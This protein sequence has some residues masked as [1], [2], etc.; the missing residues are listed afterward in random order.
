MYEDIK[1]RFDEITAGWPKGLK[2]IA[3]A[4]IVFAFIA[5]VF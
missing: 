2:I 3:I 5:V 4:A 1:K